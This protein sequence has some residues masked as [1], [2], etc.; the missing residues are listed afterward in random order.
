MRPFSCIIAA[1]PFTYFRPQCSDK[2][3]PVLGL[4]HVRELPARG[5]PR[6]SCE[7]S[8]LVALALNFFC[9]SDTTLQFG[10][11]ATPADATTYLNQG[12]D[13]SQ[14]GD[15]NRAV[16]TFSKA[17]ALKP[18]Y[19]QAWRGRAHCYL[20]LRQFG[21]AVGDYNQAIRLSSDSY[22]YEGRGDAYILQGQY[23]SAIAD[24]SE[25]IKVKPD[26]AAAY[27]VR[28]FAYLLQADTQRALA[29]WP[30]ASRP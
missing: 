18:D 19:W 8:L 15:C 4:R 16:D 3:V 28:G 1:I 20:V 6:S 23:D 21:K 9:G 29:T 14:S 30:I 17:I 5:R 27:Q 13:Q 11:T 26:Y 12:E 22:S 25:A 10:P 2:G 7:V 24:Y